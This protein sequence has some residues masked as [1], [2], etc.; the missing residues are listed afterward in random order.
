MTLF[1]SFVSLLGGLVLLL[2]GLI[3]SGRSLEEAAGIRLRA[4]LA[5]VTKNKFLGAAFG[6]GLSAI[7][8]SS[9]ATTV[10]L[11]RLTN[12]GIV[13]L[14]QAIPI[15]LGAD[16]GT[17]LTV[18]LIAL[19]IHAFAPIIMAVGFFIY[20]RTKRERGKSIGA[21]ILGFGLIFYG[22]HL[23]SE[24]I[25]LMPFL[26]Q[27]AAVFTRLSAWPLVLLLLAALL[28]ALFHSSA[29]TLAIT[30]VLG[31]AG[32][33]TLQGAVPI[34]LGANIGTCAP[35]FFASRKGAV[36]SKRLAA[37]HIVS[38]LFGTLLL[39]PLIEPF[40]YYVMGTADN[41][42]RQI[43]NAHTLFN[44]GL[45]FLFLPLSTQFTRLVTR[46]IA[47]P[48][49]LEDPA[50]P[51]YLD[52][53]LLSSP[54]FAL[55]AAFRESLRMA[56]IVQSMLQSVKSV[57]TYHDNMA[58]IAAIRH[59][60]EAVDRLNREIKHYI[61]GLSARGL[62]KKESLREMALLNF[63]GHL[64]NMGDI[65]DSNLLELGEKKDDQGVQF[66]D[67]GLQ[68]IHLFHHA[69]CHDFNEVLLS[70]ESGEKEKALRL[71]HQRGQFHQQGQSLRA[72]HI[73]RLRQ[74]VP[75]TVESSAIHLD[76]ITHF[77]RIRSH[78]TAIAHIV[79]EQ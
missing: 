55:D 10:I 9:S 59:Q 53:K 68:E 28:T 45:L 65:I 7:I 2:Y 33:L 22:L 48:S 6:A 1:F 72:A 38:K 52:A 70:F 24:T 17:T 71:I 25:R 11:V 54:P 5:R 78:I 35:A 73:E 41:L 66:S 60:E 61:I 14:S 12:A 67:A 62:S 57:F 15:L 8:Q 58:T 43:A 20:S 32:L 34:L 75:H 16:L 64:E 74:G 13:S 46:L 77:S 69:V 30:L 50:S 56:A 31:N 49:H 44:L 29:A 23:I 76:F 21:A 79:V 42:P 63:I 19:P 51:K 3:L 37:A 47:D 40:S 36:D 26:P 4:L 39:Y 27:I 18:Q